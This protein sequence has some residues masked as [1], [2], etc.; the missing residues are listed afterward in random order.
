MENGK[1][2]MTTIGEY[3]LISLAD[4]RTERDKKRLALLA[5]ESPN[6]KPSQTFGDVADEWKDKTM[7]ALSLRY[8][9]K[10]WRIL[11]D[12]ILPHVGHMPIK[13]ITAPDVLAALR[14]IEAQGKN[15]T[16]HTAHQICGQ[17]FRYAIACGYAIVNPADALKGALVP[18]VINHNAS[19]TDPVKIQGLV[20][21]MDAIDAGMVV[22][23]A[24]WFSAYVFLR[25]GEVRHIEWRDVFLDDSEIR[26]PPEK[27]KLRRL[28]IVPLAPQVKELLK[29][30]QNI[31]GAGQYVFPSLRSRRGD[32]P[33]S[34]NTIAVCLRRMGYSSDE[35]TAH[36]F[37]SMASTRLNEMGFPAD[38]IERQLAHVEGNHV[39]AAYNYAE[40][41]PERRKMMCAWADWLDGLK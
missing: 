40:Y 21:A 31:T 28:H 9:Q 32:T 41:L 29:T 1:S 5:G 7:Q 16:A 8:I 3:P 23:S 22:K 37:R 34:E 36:G 10:T 35:M 26:I 17:V 30:L 18:A 11:S 13:D 15:A 14:R 4:A 24:L 6:K 19:L 27:M 25:P 39:R 2:Y 20:R 38:A 33:M 12:Y